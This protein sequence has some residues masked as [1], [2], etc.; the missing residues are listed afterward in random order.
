[1]A[2]AAHEETVPDTKVKYPV[3]VQVPAQ[4]TEADKQTVQTF[5]DDK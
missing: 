1:M 5:A 3:L 4:A 2:H